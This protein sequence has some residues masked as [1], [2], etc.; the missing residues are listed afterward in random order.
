MRNPLEVRTRRSGSASEFS[1]YK[2]LR[3]GSPEKMSG[4]RAMT[5]LQLASI[6]REI[7]AFGL[8]ARCRWELDVPDFIDSTATCDECEGDDEGEEWGR[9]A[10][11]CCR[12]RRRVNYTAQH[13]LWLPNNIFLHILKF[14]NLIDLK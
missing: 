4:E 7:S 1:E 8:S 3:Y 14:K 2:E 11:L 12:L 9:R 6:R 5:F 10:F 13:E